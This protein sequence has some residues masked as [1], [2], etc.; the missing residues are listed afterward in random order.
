MKT[1]RVLILLVAFVLVFTSLIPAPVSVDAA[2]PVGTVK[3]KI[4]NNSKEK[5]PFQLY[6]PAY[7]FKYAKVKQTTEMDVLP[8]KYTYVMT[9]CGARITGNIEIKKKSK[10]FT[11]DACAGI[12][13]GNTTG[14]PLTVTLEGS[15]A[16]YYI[17]VPGVFK[18]SYI[19]PGTYN[20]TIVGCGGKVKKGTVKAKRGVEYI[21]T[22]TC[23]NKK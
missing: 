19:F 15:K 18:Y 21:W 2:A 4:T 20:Y 3:F 6:G 12:G 8:G 13:F 7:Y 9:V 11:I 14:K 10:P 16:T 5:V 23:G 1:R 22:I 17:S